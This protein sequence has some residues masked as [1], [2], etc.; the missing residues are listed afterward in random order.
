MYL[1][2]NF[3]NSGNV[4]KVCMLEKALGS[5]GHPPGKESVGK[6]CPLSVNRRLF[7]E[8][9]QLETQL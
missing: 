1:G 8:V 9:L 5:V 3:E 6:S 7:W 2:G 4:L